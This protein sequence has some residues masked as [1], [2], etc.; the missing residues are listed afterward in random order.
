M[1]IPKNNAN[2]SSE[3]SDFFKIVS[4]EKKHKKEQF[5]SLVG[6]LDLND[7]FEEVSIL[8]TKSKIKTKKG[9]KALKVFED[10]LSSREMEPNI[11]EEIEEIYEVVEELQEELEKPK[12]ILIE[13]A[14]GL[15]A[16]PSNVKVQQDPLTPLDQKFATLDDLQNH[17]K[18]FLSR[19]QQQLSTIGGGGETRLRY[20]DDVVGLATNSGAYDNKYLQWNSNTNNAEFVS[21]TGIGTTGLLIDETLDTVTD[22]GNT[23]TNGIGVSFLNLPVGSVISG[24]SSIVANIANANLNAV[25]EYGTSANIGI[26][27]YGITYAIVG[28]PYVVYEL[29]V[30]PSPVL[31]LNDII[32]GAAIPV[33]S[34]IIGIGTGAY[35]NVII[36][37][38]NFPPPYI[39][40][41]VNS[42]ITFARP[43]INPG[44]SVA[45]IDNTDLVLHTGGGGN[46]IT[47][48]DI[49]PYTTNVWRLGSPVK[50]F[51]E[52]WFGTGTI[53]VQDETLGT[54]QALGASDGNFYIKGGAG[55]EVGEWLLR[56]NYISIGN[57]T[58]DVYIGQTSDTGKLTVN[59]SLEV[60]TEIGD[61]T[62][63]VTR[64]GRVQIN[65][66][67]IPGN[68]PGSL[69]I[70]AS[71]D[72]S[73]QPI[74]QSGGLLHLVGPDAGNGAPARVNIEAYG[75]V[76][77]TPAFIN[78]RRARGTAA[79]PQGVQNGD[80]IF[81]L[82]ATGWATSNYNNALPNSFP[83]I[84]IIS[85]ETF[86]STGFGADFNIYA[87]GIGSTA[88]SLAGSF[89]GDG[90]SFVGN[91][92]GGI[93]FQDST[94]LTTFPSQDNKADKF[95]KVS[96]V[97]GDYV[98]SWET[99]PT[100]EGAVLY[101]GLYNVETNTPPLTDATGQAGWQY[102]VVGFGTTNFGLNGNL[103]L[104]EGD[105]LIHS[106]VHY[107]LI[108]GPNDQ[109][110]SDWNAT[111]GVSAILNKPDIVNQIIAGPGVVLSPVNGIGTV[112][113]NASGTQNLNSVLGYGNSSALGINVGVVSATS[114]IGNGVNLTGI[115]TSIVAGTGGITV[116]GSTGQVTINAT[117]QFNSDW[118]SN[119]GISSI[120]NKPT[121][122][123]AQVNSDWNAISGIS[124]ILNKP[125][126]VNQ[127][128]AGVGVTISPSNGI[129]IVTVTTTYAPVA[130]IATYATSAGI[131]TYA[132]SSGISTYAT[133]AGIATYA[134]TAGISTYATSAGIAT[135]ASTAGIAT[136]A[137]RAGIATYATT[138]GI[139][140]YA[141][142][143]GIATIAGYA[144]TA[145]ISST[146]QGLTGTPN[147]N[148]GIVTTTKLVSSDGGTFV[149]VVTATSYSGSGN[150]LT[151]IVTSI[152]AGAGVTIS[153][154]TG[155][156]TISSTP[157]NF[158]STSTTQASTLTV[159]F[160]G[161]DVIF[162]QPSANGNRTVTLTNFTANRGVRIFIT[163]HAAANTF[164][165]T[166]VT[167]S[168]CSNGSNV[169]QLGGGGAAQASMMIEIF[170]TSNAVGGVWI[171]AYGG[172]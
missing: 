26:G 44:L 21:I 39:L 62:F 115:V 154:S 156:V 69:L 30:V 148:V 120:L 70:T 16:E 106:G 122:P 132:T 67:N 84:E 42:V 168:Q 140:T 55:L 2:M 51:K 162:W 57:S 72:G 23:T 10:L 13:R 14:L 3:L 117:P 102:T 85:T 104:R 137:T 35:S 100:I 61:T 146:S 74:F 160:T 80:I 99:P 97:G 49:L 107:D 103:Y 108:P 167:A 75:S 5:N 34:K 145:G 73:Y 82:A 94:R 126:I 141:T 161:P 27:S 142:T 159:D 48:S 64:S 71:S 152:V 58:R 109:I 76:S 95:L 151:G 98:M 92:N 50:R 93:T 124:S 105:L 53:Y 96:N 121:I 110:N 112:T 118:T 37:D 29:K 111:T 116:S 135:Y 15:L 153:G 11:E 40:P 119:V 59:R 138:A 170:S 28:V 66:P 18:I 32:G 6:D 1:G 4:E 54:D 47:H 123:D 9:D 78:A 81:R 158:I 8:K 52:C 128:I 20:L 150:N 77:N 36:A 136:Y 79:S 7:I 166:G 129:G 131:A 89:K 155:Q 31:E 25:L 164:T 60:H 68:D 63:S 165:F 83:G 169:Y 144:S 56:D 33:G 163:P 88:R 139:A 65:T 12:N 86:T 41:L 46:V 143:A 133:T 45:T 127:I 24:V 101:K 157:S 22:R 19:I 171:F 114:Y 147:I 134:T 125:N 38:I 113:I 17:Y 87:V 130:G 43:V 172:V 91:P 149:G 90:L